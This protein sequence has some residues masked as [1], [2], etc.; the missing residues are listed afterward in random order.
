MAT[1]KKSFPCKRVNVIDSEMDLIRLLFL[2]HEIFYL[3]TYSK[4][5]SQTFPS[6]NLTFIMEEFSFHKQN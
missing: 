6:E 5:P 2:W 3:A 1:K 4:F